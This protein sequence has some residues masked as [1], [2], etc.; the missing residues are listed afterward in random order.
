MQ[1]VLP[2]ISHRKK[3]ILKILRNIIN[4]MPDNYDII[5]VGASISGLYS[6]WKLASSGFRVGIFD[7]K[8]TIGLPIRCGETTGNRTELERFLSIDEAW[9]ARDIE[10]CTIHYGQEKCITKNIKNFG[11]QLYRDK[12]EVYLAENA[13][14]NGAEIFLDTNIES[15]L[16]MDSAA[17]GIKSDRNENY[18]APLI[19]GA[20]GCESK[21]GRWAGITEHVPLQEA[22]SAIQYRIKS[23]FCN[24]HYLHFFIGT[25]V[26]PGGYIWVFPRSES[27]ISVGAGL[28]RSN[29]QTLKVKALLD[30]FIKEN[31][32]GS[33]CTAMITG[34]APL[35]LS[36]KNLYKNN[37]L[38]V[39]DAARQ[40]NPV[41]VGGI[42]NALEAADFAVKAILSGRAGNVSRAIRKEYS[43]RWKKNQR[44]HQKICYLLKEVFLECSDKELDSLI[45][46]AEKEFRVEDKTD[47][48]RLNYFPFFAF[49]KIFL[50]FFFKSIKHIY[51][52]WK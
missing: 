50:L 35:S 49:I 13:A 21:V 41:T 43:I 42:M 18:S 40:V 47:R 52:I 14:S 48:S 7:R 34:C 19:I 30:T 51:V 15:L 17:C 39:G 11:V 37:V 32:P 10:G 9:I 12:F 1:G 20:D 2:R 36:P 27:E 24:D 44:R 8:H 26:I 31:I 25:T 33:Q 16:W 38:V 28:Y 29:N 46:F 5:I 45:K 4:S 6:G 3:E 23:N 22:F